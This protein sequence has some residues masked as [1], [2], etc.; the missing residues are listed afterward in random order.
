MQSAGRGGGRRGGGGRE[1]G[2]FSEMV[3]C[4]KVC[5]VNVQHQKL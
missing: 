3:V 1:G 5:G 2:E 4:F